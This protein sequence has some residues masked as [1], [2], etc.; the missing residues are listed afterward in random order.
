MGVG[1]ISNR[2]GWLLELLTELIKKSKIYHFILPVIVM[3]TERV[4]YQQSSII[5]CLKKLRKPK[6]DAVLM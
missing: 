3:L 5:K 1:W 6:R 2:S 4:I